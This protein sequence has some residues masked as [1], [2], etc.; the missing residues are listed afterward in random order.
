MKGAGPSDLAAAIDA[1]LEFVRIP[2]VSSDPER[3]GDCLRAA[4]WVA[5]AFEESGLRVERIATDGAPIICGEDVRGRARKV[6]F[7]AHYDVQPPDPLDEWRSPPFEP[8]RVRGDGEERI[9]ARGASDDKGQLVAV[10]AGLRAWRR[11]H[12]DLPVDVLF[13]SEGEEEIGSPGLQGLLEREPERFRA[14]A[15]VIADCECFDRGVP[16][17]FY[18][19]RGLAYVEIEVIGPHCDLHSGTY[20]GAVDNPANVLA[21]MLA[22]C[23]DAEGRI[24]I[25]GFY[26]KVL[27]I[28]D[29]ESARI[30]AVPFDEEAFRKE[31]GV[32]ALRGEIG[33]TTL[34]RRWAR[35]TIDVNGI[36][37]GF[38]GKG[39]KTVLPARASA[40]LSSRLVPGQDPD[41]VSALLEGFF[42]A[43]APP[44][45]EVRVTK[46]PGAKPVLIPTSGPAIDAARRAAVA[47]FGREPLFVRNGATIPIVELF[48]NRAKTPCVPTGFALPDDRIHSPNE[49]FEIACLE[50]GIAWTARFIE[51]FARA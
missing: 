15:A 1:L 19:L 9:V 16:A 26:D 37:A 18:G 14:D 49:K 28:D 21:A 50:Q 35:P 46:H 2:S 29:A 5:K 39:A 38:Q 27:A 33:H 36:T 8:T 3:R 41:E 7:Y 40:K 17:I 45:V 13:V 47:V 42:R 51:E 30:A 25:P 24:A 20:G 31:A 12:G 22:A 44:S 43:I 4:D 6:L 48:H 10:L 34:E 11:E 32:P 23:H